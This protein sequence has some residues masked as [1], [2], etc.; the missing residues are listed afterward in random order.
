[1]FLLG[2]VLDLQGS[3]KAMNIPVI[4]ISLGIPE[5]LERAEKM[6]RNSFSRKSKKWIVLQN[7]HLET[8]WSQSFLKLLEV[9]SFKILTLFRLLFCI[10]IFD[11]FAILLSMI[12]RNFKIEP[13]LSSFFSCFHVILLKL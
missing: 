9:T 11:T 10:M 2:P 1:M 6:I 4:T 12:E 3:G 7:C 13:H 5:Q 8:R